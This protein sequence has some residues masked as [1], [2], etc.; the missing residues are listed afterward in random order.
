[1][2]RSKKNQI[3]PE[4]LA[5]PG[6]DIEKK[7]KDKYVNGSPSKSKKRSQSVKEPTE[8]Y[9]TDRETS[10]QVKTAY[11]KIPIYV[12]ITFDPCQGIR[13]FK[14]K[15]DRNKVSSIAEFN[16]K[17]LEMT[18]HYA[19][20]NKKEIYALEDF[21]VTGRGGLLSNKVFLNILRVYGTLAHWSQ[22]IY[23][24]T[25]I[26]PIINFQFLA[27]DSTTDVGKLWNILGMNQ[28]TQKKPNNLWLPS[29]DLEFQSRIVTPFLIV[30][31]NNMTFVRKK[32]RKWL[33]Y[34][35]ERIGDSTYNSLLEILG[36][37]VSNL[38]NHGNK[39]IF[40]ISVWPSGQIEILWSNPI[41]HLADWWP[42][43]DRDNPARGLARG[44]LESEGVG[45]KYI[46][47]YVLPKYKGVFIVNW[48]THDLIFSL[49]KDFSIIGFNSRSEDYL[50]RSI[51]FHLYLF[52]S[53]TRK[54]S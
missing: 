9:Q 52:C 16:C 41:E 45:I 31:E 30:N 44:L 22:K 51:L 43:E 17:P 29:S 34:I 32:V 15:W 40:G 42:P 54:R 13:E 25:G 48:K 19:V 28:L 7:A 21:Y 6:L 20:P 23:R 50:P 4:Q 8:I 37:V 3:S 14:Q 38:V 10:K 11:P 12:G 5:I 53:E 36:E 39:G 2:G 1:M 26:K 47:E 27:P 33:D 35:Y 49:E 46:Y 18:K 24:E